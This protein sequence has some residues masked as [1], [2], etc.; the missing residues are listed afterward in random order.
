MKS[1][2]TCGILA[3]VLL[4]VL[5]C[6]VKQKPVPNRNYTVILH[7]ADSLLRIMPD[8][9]FAR[10]SALTRDSVQAGESLFTQAL[11][12]IST[13]YK[14]KAKYDTAM[15]LAARALQLS[16]KQGDTLLILHSLLLNGNLSTD[17]LRSK[18]ALQF[19][20]DGLSMAKASKI[21]L[22]ENGFLVGIGN[23]QLD[24][25]DYPA[26]FRSFTEA[27]RMAG[28]AGATDKESTAFNNLSLILKFQG[29][30]KEAIRYGRISLE[31]DK[32]SG[33]KLDYANH[34]MNMGVFYEN[35]K[36]NDSALWYYNKAGEICTKSG[37]SMIM[38]KVRFNRSNVFILQNRYQ[39]AINDLKNVQR[40]CVR[41]AI[42][43]GQ[44]YAL[45]S[46][47]EVYSKTG[48]A[49]SALEK[50]D[51]AIALA[52]QHGIVNTLANLYETRYQVLDALGRQKEALST[53]L[54][55][56]HIS[57]SINSA[58]KQSEI[59]KLNMQFNTERKDNEIV[60]L[61]D[62]LQ[63]EAGTRRMQSLII[64]LLVLLLTGTAGVSVYI[65]NL[66]RARTDAYK[67]L[68][69]IY[70][71]RQLAL[72]HTEPAAITDKA[73]NTAVETAEKP[74]AVPAAD[75]LP[76]IPDIAFNKLKQ[77][78]DE[79]KIF[80]DAQ[81]S[82]E[83]L[84]L[85]TGIG[86]K[87]LTLLIKIRFETGFYPLLNMYRVE[88]AMKLL[89]DRANDKLKVEYIG[90]KSGFNSRPTFYSTFTQYTG[91]PPAVYRQAMIEK[92]LPPHPGLP[93]EEG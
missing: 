62:R 15:H 40:Y 81:L 76:L 5:S 7:E 63:A 79:D 89:D 86:K 64:V 85:A 73:L 20:K 22:E 9:A 14:G 45:S 38:I 29:D 17:C 42:A 8:S 49:A 68:Q 27:A 77:L 23:I 87:E 67:A 92:D 74:G 46:L 61:S 24:Q 35:M 39:A 43:E 50:A 59:S 78:F 75:P 53:A 18:E 47:A 66:L 16:V 60:T 19:Y 1:S 30:F 51:S 82:L 90:L 69:A 21:A 32:K 83:K 84:A 71:G 93:G 25:A 52:K 26:A 58:K 12:G 88:H 55:A 41:H 31:L 48:N 72:E 6:S 33:K 37:D 3:L 11:I 91:L 28:L 80:L 44:V 34:L 4:A 56:Q 70:A 54:L 36:R 2:F 10:Y 57:D 65:F 13:Y